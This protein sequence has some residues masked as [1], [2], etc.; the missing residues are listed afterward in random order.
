MRGIVLA[1][2]W[3]LEYKYNVYV[4]ESG[5]KAANVNSV[6]GSAH[7]RS[8][9]KMFKKKRAEDGKA[10]RSAVPLYF[11]HIIEHVEVFLLHPEP[12]SRNIEL[13]ALMLAEMNTRISVTAFFR[14]EICLHYAVV[15]YVWFWSLYEVHR[16]L[17]WPSITNCT[18]IFLYRCF[19]VSC[20]S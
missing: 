12:E 2:N 6:S 7:I 9:Q 4:S 10:P 17:Q 1:L 13:H 20:K 16:M 19:Y 11:E 14:S 15:W 18:R 8:F 5:E 3:A